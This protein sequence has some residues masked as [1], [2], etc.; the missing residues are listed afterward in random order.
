MKRWHESLS[1]VLIVVGMLLTVMAG[2]LSAVRAA[3]AGD[4]LQAVQEAWARAAQA[5]AY[6][7]RTEIVQ[8]TYPAPALA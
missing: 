7:F 6:Q 3:D 5:G 4:P 8:T 2:G 1:R